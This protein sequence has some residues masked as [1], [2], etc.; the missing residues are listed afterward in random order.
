MLSAHLGHR[1]DKPLGPFVQLLGR[2]GLT[3]NLLTFVGLC[4]SLLAAY[5]IAR[6]KLL[7][8][9]LLILSGS[10]FDILDG[11]MARSMDL[12]SKFGAFLDSVFDRFSDGLPMV[13]L[14]FY[15][16]KTGALEHVLLCGFVMIGVFLVPYTRARAE[17][18]IFQCQVGLMERAERIG[19]LSLGLLSQGFF[20]QGLSYSLWLLALLTHFT[21]SQRIWYT[22]KQLQSLPSYEEE[23]SQQTHKK[24]A[25]TSDIPSE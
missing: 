21:V 24:K 5:E 19:V 12:E 2:R 22:Y 7:L 15:F 9:A 3:P 14:L 11:V 23:P 20:A 17:T 8:A 16:G 1:L 4:I 25:I 13:G 6:G 10:F 18:L